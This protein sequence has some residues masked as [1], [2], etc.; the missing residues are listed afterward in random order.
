MTTEEQRAKYRE[1]SRR[2]Y[3]K[4]HDKILAQ[5]KVSRKKYYQENK[6]V[7][8]LKTRIRYYKK[9]GDTEKVKEL[10]KKLY[11]V[12]EVKQNDDVSQFEVNLMT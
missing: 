8:I 11:G 4:N 3:E 9:T 12:L 6:E 10:E 1:K 2:A 5:K 7:E